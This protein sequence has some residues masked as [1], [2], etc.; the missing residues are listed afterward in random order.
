MSFKNTVKVMTTAAV[1]AI[2]A[3]FAGN[4]FAIPDCGACQIGAQPSSH[5]FV[6][7][8]TDCFSC[9]APA[10]PAPTPVV[11][12][13]PV[14]TQ[15]PVITAE[16]V[17]KPVHVAKNDPSTGGGDSHSTGHSSAGHDTHGR[18]GAH[19]SETGSSTSSTKRGHGKGHNGSDE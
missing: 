10:A 5:T 4:A 19:M 14:V 6:T 8:T 7:A 9:H 18:S 15:D 11:T 12:T 16:P 3:I 13:P 17:V 1:L 2:P